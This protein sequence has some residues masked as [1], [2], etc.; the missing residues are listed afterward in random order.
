MVDCDCDD[1]VSCDWCCGRKRVTKRV[2]DAKHQ[3]G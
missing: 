2:L 1:P 3:L